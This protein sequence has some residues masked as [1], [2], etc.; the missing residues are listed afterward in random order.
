ATVEWFSRCAQRLLNALRQRTPRGRLYEVD[1]RLRPSGSQGL[2]VTSLAGWRRY[3]EKHAR[4]WERQA[5]TKLRPVAGDRALGAE[6]EQ[7]A[8]ET[9]Y[10]SSPDPRMVAEEVAKMRER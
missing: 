7:L 1:T 9:V 8:I 5:L 10:G 6:V 4:L 2:L 3:H